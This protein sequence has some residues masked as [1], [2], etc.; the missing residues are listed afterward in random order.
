L[1]FGGGEINSVP[2]IGSLPGWSQHGRQFQIQ[3]GKREKTPE[4]SFGGPFSK[5][6][7]FGQFQYSII[8]E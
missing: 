3:T 5:I 4:S 1:R 6:E 8:K 7:V 2:N